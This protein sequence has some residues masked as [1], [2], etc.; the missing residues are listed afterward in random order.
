MADGDAERIARVRRDW[1]IIP[2]KKELDLKPQPWHVRLVRVFRR[3]RFDMRSV[4]LWA[5]EEFSQR[6]LMREETPLKHDNILK[7]SDAVWIYA[8]QNQWTITR[9]ALRH[10]HSGEPDPVLR[11]VHV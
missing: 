2:E 6:S 1:R 4:Y 10:L 7:P 5:A 11:T 8:L 9:S 3:T